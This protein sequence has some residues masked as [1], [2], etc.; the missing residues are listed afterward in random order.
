MWMMKSLAQDMLGRIGKLPL[1]QELD[2]DQLRSIAANTR[3]IQIGK[4]EMLFQKGDEAK[5]FYLV[6]KG[7]IKL[8]FP[9]IQGNEKVVA[10]VGTGQTFGEAAMFLDQRYPVRAEALA[11]SDLLYFGSQMIFG[12]LAQ[13][14]LFARKLLAGLSFRLHQLVQ[15]VELYSQRSSAQRVIGYLLQLCPAQGGCDMP[16]TIDL[17]TTKQVVASRLNLTPETLSRILHDL[18]EE[19]LIEMQGRRIHIPHPEP[20]R[21]YDI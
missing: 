15:D 3:E 20:L 21:L 19:G 14:P 7:Q 16:L 17:P 6:L 13:D 5:G 8:A 2:A 4:G 10:I 1:F 12:L 18:S 9:S 11:N